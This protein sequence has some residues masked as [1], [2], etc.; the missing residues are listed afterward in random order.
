MSNKNQ[1]SD[2]SSMA[3]LVTE[4]TAQILGSPSLAAAEEEAKLLAQIEEEEAAARAAK[5]L[6]KQQAEAQASAIVEDASL[7]PPQEPS[8]PPVFLET[9]PDRIFKVDNS[10]FNE[11]Q[12]GELLK[13]FCEIYIREEDKNEMIRLGHPADGFKAI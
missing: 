12:F 8:E 11:R 2:P 4:Q 9:Q 7:Q 6:L 1:K 3:G 13:R 5:A 10:K